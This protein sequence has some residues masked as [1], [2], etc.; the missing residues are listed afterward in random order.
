MSRTVTAFFDNRAD[1]EAAKQRLHA[2]QIDADH[3][4]IHDQSSQGYRESGAYSD[5]EDR[6]VWDSIKNAFLPD[7]D[8]HTYEEGLRRGGV[9]LTADVDADKVDEVIRVLEG[10]NSVDLEDRSQQWRSQGWDYGAAGAATGLVADT[11]TDRTSGEGF[12]GSD[13]RDASDERT[14]PIVEERLQV[15]KREVERGGARVRSYVTENPVHEQ[16]RLRNE[17]VEVERRAVDRPLTDADDDAF[18]EQTIEMTARGEEAMVD[19]E[20]RVVEEVV[21]RKT[22]DEQVRDIDDTVRRTQVEVDEDVGKSD[23]GTTGS[24]LF[25]GTDRKTDY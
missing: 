6:G 22:S 13:H 8:R 19:K 14:I 10:S 3:V 9:L 17:R 2:A 25:G 15:G 11:D 23:R 7:E 1:A 24:G 21:V 20:A 12:I 16:V 18:R 4:H 5:H